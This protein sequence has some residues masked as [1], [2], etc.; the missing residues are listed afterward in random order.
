MFSPLTYLYLYNKTTNHSC[1]RYG[2]L[3]F[4]THT[5]TTHSHTTIRLLRNR[6]VVDFVN[7]FIISDN[8]SLQ[9][10]VLYKLHKLSLY[11][12]KI[13]VV[14]TIQNVSN[15]VLFIVIV[16]FKKQAPAYKMFLHK[17]FYIHRFICTFFGPG[18]LSS[19]TYHKHIS[20]L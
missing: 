2:W 6:R 11:S 17:Y 16:Y 9:W 10:N 3:W 18:F 13:N 19:I 20:V 4:G 8:V 12:D 5:D 14:V 7:V 15:T 1:S